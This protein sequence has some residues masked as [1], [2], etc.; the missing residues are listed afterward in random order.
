PAP[1][2]RRAGLESASQRRH[3]ALDARLAARHFREPS[4][5]GRKLAPRLRRLARELAPL[6]LE[7]LEMSQDTLGLAAGSLDILLA[8]QPRRLLGMDRDLQNLLSASQRFD[9]A[10]Q[11]LELPRGFFCLEG[12]APQPF[13]RLARGPVP[14]R[15]R[16]TVWPPP[17]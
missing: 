11:R 12:E 16:M 1:S 6:R 17:G 2:E 10:V 13:R 14:A 4:V 3:L 8:A 15:A 5:Q 9:L 7:C